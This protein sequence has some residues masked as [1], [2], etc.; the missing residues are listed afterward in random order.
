M[1][2]WAA[3]KI[4]GRP[5]T[6][7]WRWLSEDWLRIVVASLCVLSAFLWWQG[8]RAASQRDGALEALQA[9]QSAHKQTEANYRIAAAQAMAEAEMNKARVETRYVEI[10]NEADKNIRAQ[11]AAAIDSLRAAKAR[12]DSSGS[13]ATGLPGIAN[14]ASDT[15]GAGEASI[16]DDA[17]ICAENTVKA[18]GWLDWY[19]AASAVARQ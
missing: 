4:I 7:F 8:S 17:M 18:Q 16:M 6:A 1:W 12:A 11:L 19:S 5:L 14:A 3:L 10:E 15:D 2:A 9:E 13:D